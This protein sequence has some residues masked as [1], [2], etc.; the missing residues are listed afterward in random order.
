MARSALGRSGLK[1]DGRDGLKVWKA[2]IFKK[3]PKD[4]IPKTY[5]LIQGDVL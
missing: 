1:I 2:L 4:I 5:Q 3:L